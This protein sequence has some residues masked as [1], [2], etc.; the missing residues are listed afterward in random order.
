MMETLV[1]EKLTGMLSYLFAGLS[2][3]L[4]EEHVSREISRIKL[5][6]MLR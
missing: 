5:T 4:D 2:G 3:E 1:S 6:E